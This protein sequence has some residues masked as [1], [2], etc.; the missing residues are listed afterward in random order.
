[1]LLLRILPPVLCLLVLVLLLVLSVV[2]MVSKVL[3]PLPPVVIVVWV[4]VVS[5][6]V[7]EDGERF[8]DT[9]R[10]VISSKSPITGTTAAT[11]TIM[12]DG[13]TTQTFMT[14]MTTAI[15]YIPASAATVRLPPSPTTPPQAVQLCLWLNLG[16]VPALTWPLGA[17]IPF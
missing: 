2:A 3:V 1:M 8:V 7:R 16:T 13:L 15:H 6:H 5:D 12:A 9:M 17:I 10:M 11:M 4:Q 14:R